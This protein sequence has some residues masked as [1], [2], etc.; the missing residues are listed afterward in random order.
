MPDDSK[1]I[2]L[3]PELL[4]HFVVAAAFAGAAMQRHSWTN[5]R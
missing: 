4:T 2:G 3:V 5:N 1:W